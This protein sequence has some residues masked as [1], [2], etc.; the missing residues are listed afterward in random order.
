M[1][2]I[3]VEYYESGK[4]ILLIITGIGGTTKGY[5]NKYEKIAR[6]VIKKY[7]F[8]V[9][10]ATSPFGS[11]LHTE[12]NLDYIMNYIKS[13]R[14]YDYKVYAMGNS[15]GANILL[16]HSQKFPQIKKVLA[17]NPVMNI[18]IHLLKRLQDSTK[19]INIVFGEKDISSKFAKLVPI[20]KNVRVEILPN[21][22]HNFTN[23]LN[24]FLELPIKYLIE[25]SND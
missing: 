22:D 24:V 1:E 10:V 21:I 12:Q 11:W 18:N 14:N 5:K 20:N 19:D 16:W 23:N 8:S 2:K 3:D 7:N 17:V 4:D 25:K 9:V 6:N 13:K 15:V